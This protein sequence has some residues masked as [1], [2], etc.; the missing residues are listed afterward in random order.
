MIRV[1]QLR[2]VDGQ[3]P[4]LEGRLPDGTRIEVRRDSDDA[5]AWIML[6]SWALVPEAPEIAADRPKLPSRKSRAGGGGE[7]RHRK[8]PRAVGA[9]WAAPDPSRA[10][11]DARVDGTQ[12]QAPACEPACAGAREAR[13]SAAADL[14]GASIA[15]SDQAVSGPAPLADPAKNTDAISTADPSAP[16]HHE[17]D[18]T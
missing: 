2:L 4:H 9:H 17:G 8:L 15:G 11:A 5:G 12:V 3:R 14:I 18:P 10:R 7:V 6:A 16:I 1:A 13:P